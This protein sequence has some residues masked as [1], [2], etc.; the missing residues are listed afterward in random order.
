M[1]LEQRRQKALER[2]KAFY[3]SAEYQ[4][5]GAVLTRN[6]AKNRDTIEPPS[7]NPVITSKKRK[8]EDVIPVSKKAKSDDT[9][10]VQSPVAGT[11][12]SFQQSQLSPQTADNEEQ[13]DYEREDGSEPELFDRAT[14]VY[15][16]DN[17]QVNV[18]KEMF[19]R[20]KL[21]R[22]EDHSYVMR[23]KLKNKTTDYPM[24]DSLMDVLYT[25]FTFMINNLKTFIPKTADEDNLIYLCIH[26]QGMT[27]SLNSGSFKLQSVETESLVQDVLLM[28]ENYVNS[29]STINVL[30]NSFKCYFRVLSVP[31]VN[32]SKHRRKTIPMPE[33]IPSRLGCRLNRRFLISY[34]SGLYDIPGKKCKTLLKIFVYF[35][36]YKNLMIFFLFRWLS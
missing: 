36:E 8:F 9:V 7:Q 26:Q 32:Y 16:D 4:Q 3:D 23:I 2:F 20:Q 34:K 12:F 27:N 1:D 25:A 17:L 19:K 24:L 10:R 11:S 31:H 21:F 30:D 29:D 14:T 18:V 13:M 6:Q 22:I 33:R 28:F 15:E 5:G 35:F